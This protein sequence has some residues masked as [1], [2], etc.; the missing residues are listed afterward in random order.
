MPHDIAVVFGQ[1]IHYVEAGSGPTLLL[2]HGL[3]DT[4]EVWRAE[5]PALARSYHVIAIDQIGSG[6]SDKPMLSYRPQ[7]IVDFLDGFMRVRGLR[8]ATLV[9]NSLGGWVAALMSIEHPKRVDA[10]VLVDSGGLAALN[11]VLGARLLNALRMSSI[12]DLR[13]LFQL[14]DPLDHASE[15]DLRSAFAERVSAGDGYGYTVSQLVDSIE[16]GDD[17][18]DGRLGRIRC[19]GPRGRP[20]SLA[21]WRT[22][23]SR[24]SWLAAHRARALRARTSALMPVGVREGARELSA[25][26]NENGE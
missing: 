11:K 13:L 9:G 23:T 19:L 17:M 26:A 7:T 21:L 14:A 10:L 12:E 1:R 22:A 3:G 2:L 25:F 16:R 20:Y 24:H 4:L 15:K 5:I 6:L 18:L 8:T